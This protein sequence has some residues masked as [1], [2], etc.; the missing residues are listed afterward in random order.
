MVAVL[1]AL[2]AKAHMKLTFTIFMITCLA[3]AARA[4][5]QSQSFD[6]DP[7]WEG[8]NN[9]INPKAPKKVTQD[10]GYSTSNFAGEGPGEMGGLISRA[11]EPAYYAAKIA[12]KTLD[13]KLSAAGTF[14]LTQS[15]SGSGVFFG[16]FNAAQPGAS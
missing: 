6:S 16:F 2:K 14:A 15:S 8:N 4:G 13:D 3:G 10:F 5:E 11:S 7:R 12:P 9:R 1:V